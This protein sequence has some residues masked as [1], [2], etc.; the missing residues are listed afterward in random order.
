M[1]PLLH[2]G[3]LPMGADDRRVSVTAAMTVE[4]HGRERAHLDV[5]RPFSDVRRPAG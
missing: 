5:P 3:H 4:T 2:S 1:P